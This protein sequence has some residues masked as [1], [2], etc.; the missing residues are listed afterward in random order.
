MPLITGGFYI[1]ARC[2]QDAA[3]ST[4]P[5]HVREI[6]DW[7][8]KESNHAENNQFKRGQCMRSYKDIQ[9]GL[10]WYVGWRKMSYNKWQCEN[11]M[12]W[13]TKENMITTQKTTRG[14]IISLVNY[15]K[16]QTVSHYESHKRTTREPQ[17]TD[18]INNNDKN[19]KNEKKEETTTALATAK[20][21]GGRPVNWGSPVCPLHSGPGYRHI[22]GTG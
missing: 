22:Q 19:E 4:Q 12:K 14:L 17:T 11:A 1:K 10:A 2:I 21:E 18:T 9:D 13:L 16:Y 15:D 3:I 7:L 20:V 5:P 6:W 8:I